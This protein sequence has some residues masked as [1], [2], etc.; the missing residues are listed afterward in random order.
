M[1]TERLHP[2]SRVSQFIKLLVGNGKHTAYPFCPCGILHRRES[3]ATYSGWH[4]QPLFAGH[5]RELKN[6]LLYPTISS[7][8]LHSQKAGLILTESTGKQEA[9]P[10][11]GP[12]STE[13]PVIAFVISQAR[14]TAILS[15]LKVRT[16]TL[17]GPRCLTLPPLH[18]LSGHNIPGDLPSTPTAQTDVCLCRKKPLWCGGSGSI[19]GGAHRIWGTVAAWLAQFKPVGSGWPERKGEF[20]GCTL[21]SECSFSS[22]LWLGCLQ[23][24]T[25]WSRTLRQLP[26]SA[27]DPGRSGCAGFPGQVLL[28]H[29]SPSPRSGVLLPSSKAGQHCLESEPY[30]GLR[31][32][33]E[34]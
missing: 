1:G 11:G 5:Q 27:L 29:L 22:T 10:D 19:L 16:S 3:P 34:L 31:G 17:R 23:T 20:L 13:A 25:A 4:Q 33:C 18:T 30:S 15:L 28:E 9:G 26:F 7:S 24:G 14:G 21:A 32:L 6:T 12:V 8:Y 2:S